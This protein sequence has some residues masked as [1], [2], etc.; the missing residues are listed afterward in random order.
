M[1]ETLKSTFVNISINMEKFMLM[2]KVNSFW[3]FEFEYM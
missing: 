2:L 1:S 3:E